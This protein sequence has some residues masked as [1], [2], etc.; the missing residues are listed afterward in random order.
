MC[1]T[2]RVAMNDCQQ[3]L[4]CEH[5]FF[6]H[7]E[8]KSPAP[9]DR[10]PHRRFVQCRVLSSIPSKPVVEVSLRASR[11]EG[12]LDDDDEPEPDSQVQAYVVATTKKGCF[13]RLSQ[14]VKGR[15]ILKELC[16]GFLPKPDKAFPPGRL[17]VGKVKSVHN[18]SKKGKAE[19]REVDL[20]MRESVL[21]ESEEKL[22]FGD[23][24]VGKK[25]KGSVRRIE[26]YGVF[27]RIDKSDI[28]GLVHKSECS[29][30]YVKDLSRLYD[31][32]DLVKV[33]VLKKDEE[34]KQLGFSMK[35]SHFENDSDSD[36]DVSSIEDDES[37]AEL[38]EDSEASS[39]DENFVSKLAKSM[40]N[41]KDEDI[42]TGSND[43]SS[44]SSGT[45][46]KEEFESEDSDDDADYSR[47]RESKQF[48]DTN[49]GFDWGG[50]KTTEG[51][52]EDLSESE[53]DEDTSDSEDEG[54]VHKS[55]H[56]SRRKQAQ[57]RKEEQE[58]TRREVALA[59]G[60]ADEN[61]ETAADFE[62]LLAGNPNSSEIWIKYM[63]FHLSL[64]DITAAR[65][66]ASRAF[67]RIE[68]REER[69]K[70]NVWCALLTLELKYGSE[71]NLHETIGRACQ[72]NNPKHVY[73]RVCEM[74]EKDPS[75][76]G[77]WDKV[78]EMYTKMCKKF[79]SKK[80]AWIAH[81]EYLL[82][83]GRQ[84]DAYSLSKK[85][86]QSLP[87]YKH[88][89][90]MSKFAQLVFE[91]GSPERARTL[92]DGLLLKYPKR[93]DIFSVYADK[94]VKHGEISTARAL[95]E[96]VANPADATLKLKLSDKQMKRFFKKWYGFE[97]QHGTEESQE[98]VKDAARRYVEQT[99]PPI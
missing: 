55:S 29:D 54:E 49:V 53:N 78:D 91:Y 72:Q 20:D 56:K 37:M 52:D 84:E 61:P 11:I 39:D 6:E 95:F 76:S 97:E 98:N 86:M 79:K 15:V 19:K 22:K 62:R 30:S 14:K 88:V 38:V 16:D 96:R 64:A 58:I 68:F 63:A 75:A 40:E 8:S 93:L 4:T 48:M 92:F 27:V 60:T 32:G 94:E 13:L 46:S 18:A 3:L 35:A 5:C 67:E 66:V 71:S 17:V 2:P 24:V 85:A 82:R 1:K 51:Q 73:L 57:R 59:D 42:E 23:I 87:T 70:L 89:E 65:E 26:D 36:D 77:G 47:E 80:K 90:T 81:M 43:T 12:D 25:Y 45:G 33:L 99:T 9:D 10:F 41:T 44:D 69:E 28:S 7:R 31:H 83:S 50:D 21:L 34:K 74:M